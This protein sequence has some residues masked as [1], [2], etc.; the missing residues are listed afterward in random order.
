ML[1]A[2]RAWEA[3]NLRAL[4]AQEAQALREREREQ[5]LTYTREDAYSAVRARPPGGQGPG[6]CALGSESTGS[7]FAG[8]VLPAVIKMRWEP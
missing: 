5:L 4:R 3:Q 7:R 8:Y 2:L 6:T 1:S